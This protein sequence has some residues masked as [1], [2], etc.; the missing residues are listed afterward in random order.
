WRPNM[1]TL[2]RKL[3]DSAAVYGVAFSPDSQH[4]AAGSYD[5]SAYVKVW[6]IA[7]GEL[8]WQGKGHERPVLTVAFSPDGQTLASGGV[9][10]TVRLWDA[11]GAVRATLSGHQKDITGVAFSPDGKLLASVSQDATARLWDVASGNL[12][13]QLPAEGNMLYGAAFSPDGDVLAVVGHR[14]VQAWLVDSGAAVEAAG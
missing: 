11:S 9:D 13:K 6:N 14:G 7:S 2:V 8:A 3:S 5:H 10:K 1:S 12:V 4:V